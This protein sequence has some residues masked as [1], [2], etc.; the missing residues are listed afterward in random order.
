M[1]CCEVSA[2]ATKKY[3]LLSHI[4]CQR[5]PFPV[6]DSVLRNVVYFSK[7]KEANGERVDDN[8]VAITALVEWLVIITIDVRRYDTSTLH[9]IYQLICLFVHMGIH[10]D[11]L[12]YRQI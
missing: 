4:R 3:E 12:L 7:Q 6:S 1:R 2:Q 8:Q 10:N 9:D 11:L 5:V